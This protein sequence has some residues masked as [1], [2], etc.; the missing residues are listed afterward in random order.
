SFLATCSASQESQLWHHVG[1]AML[2]RVSSE[3][4]WL[5]T[6]GGGVPWLH[7]R[8]DNSPKYYSHRLYRD[9]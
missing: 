1:K 4:V 2:R 8:L 9:G 3:P 6:A 5:S 7:I